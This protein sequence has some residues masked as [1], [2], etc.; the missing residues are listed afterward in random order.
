[1]KKDSHLQNNI[2]IALLA[3]VILLVGIGLGFLYSASQ[4]ASLKY[5]NNQ[6][7]YLIKQGIFFIIGIFFFMA[8]FFI[9]I[10]FYKKNIKFI[11]VITLILL[12]V[13]LIPGISKE[14]AG[15]R[16]WLNLVIFQFQPSEIAKLVVIFYLSFVLANKKEFIE[17]F[18]KGILPPL[19]L[20]GFISFLILAEN[21]FSTTFLVLVTSMTIFFLAGIRLLTFFML[22]GVGGI[23]GVLMIFLAQY[24]ITRFFA[25]LNPW[26]DPLGSGWQY[27]QS[28][29]C[30]SLGKFFGKG[31]GESAQKSFALPEAQ[32]DYIFAIIGEEGGAFFAIVVVLLFTAFAFIGLNIAKRSKDKTHFLLASGIASLV[33]IQAMVNIGVVIG[34]LP[35]TGIT[36]PFISAGGTSLVIFMFACG[37]LF[38][39]AHKEA[40]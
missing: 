29:K 33:F 22:I 19:L 38:N 5:F 31:I 39:I 28:M 32:N 18:Y 16:R 7:Y 13:T 1:M 26:E 27:I 12:I 40:G 4:P 37:V 36:L 30:F 21:D 23:A 8:G 11:V 6:F 14:V 17:D 34:I 20:V 10:E 15:G 9:K 25:F 24:R 2:G 3:S 35:S